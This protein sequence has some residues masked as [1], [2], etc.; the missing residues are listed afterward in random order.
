MADPPLPAN[1][2]AR[3]MILQNQ[4]ANGKTKAERETAAAEYETLMTQRLK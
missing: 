2:Y 3:C 1:V 4:I